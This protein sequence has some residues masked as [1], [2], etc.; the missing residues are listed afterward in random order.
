VKWKYP[1]WLGATSRLAG[2]RGTVFLERVEP[3]LSRAPGFAIAACVGVFMPAA[4]FAAAPSIEDFV[5]SPLVMA[6]SISPKGTQLIYLQTDERG[7]YGL[8]GVKLANMTPFAIT[9]GDDDVY[10]YTWLTEERVAFSVAMRRRYSRGLYL[11]DLGAKAAAGINDADLTD[12]V[13]VLEEDR[14]RMYVWFIA[15]ETHRRMGLALL[16]IDRR[17]ASGYGRSVD[18]ALI[19]HWVPAPPGE[20]H[21]WMADK[22]GQVRIGFTFHRDQLKAWTHRNDADPWE[23]LP[24]DPVASDLVTFSGDGNGVYVV[25]DDGGSP[26]RALR[27]L[28]LRTKELGPVIFQDPEFTLEDLWVRFSRKDD[29]MVGLTFTRDVPTTRWFNER[30]AAVQAAVDAKL[31]GRLNLLSDWDREE[32]RFVVAALSD[33]HPSKYYV[34]EAGSGKLMA[35]P[36]SA[37][38]IDASKMR[39]MQ[40]IRYAA[41]DGL[42]LQGYLTLPEKRDDGTKPA[43]I[44]VPHGGPWAR[45]EWGWNAEVQFLASRGYAV[46]QPNYRGSTGFK[47]EVTEKRSEF[48]AMLDDVLDGTEAACRAGLVDRDRVAIY[49]GSFGGYLALAGAAFAPD[50]FKCAISF[51]GVFDWER[52]LEQDR[53]RR[54]ARAARHYNRRYIGDPKADAE[55]FNAMSPIKHAAKIK[56]PLLLAHGTSDSVVDVEQTK[57]LSRELKEHGVV[58]EAVYFKEEGH[59]LTDP[60]NEAR[61]LRQLEEFL[62][63]HL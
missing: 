26:T 27:L 44:V 46:F 56:I 48:R 39:P 54:N 23:E 40:T 28:D 63:R 2:K 5:R 6:A 24:L 8:G 14:S 62:A 20:I 59:G 49:G 50:R 45:D 31:P 30:F 25:H 1:R 57:I 61:F 33:R 17:A 16:D 38:W 47:R 55:R 18:D 21:G 12:I 58:F 22:T 52:L 10:D 3:W 4:V 51:A 11:Y 13:S 42:R 41:H 36:E 53:Y 37:P 43:L 32:T 19:A 9:L 7:H 15:G 35:L 60:A 29:A 34:Y